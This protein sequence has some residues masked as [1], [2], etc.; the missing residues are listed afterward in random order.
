M[1]QATKAPSETALFSEMTGALAAETA[2]AAG[3][4]TALVS[5]T[6]DMMGEGQ[7]AATRVD[8]VRATKSLVFSQGDMLDGAGQ[9]LLAATAV[10]K[11]LR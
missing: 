8:I 6:F 9:R 10:H 1:T 2:R 4:P 11:I 7:P 3:A 5:I